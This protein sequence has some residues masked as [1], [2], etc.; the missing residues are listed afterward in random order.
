MTVRAFA[1]RFSIRHSAVI[2]WQKKRNN[3]TKMVW[4]TEKDIRLF[5]LDELENKSTALQDLYRSLK[6]VADET[7][8]PIVIDGKGLA[9]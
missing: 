7:T 4:S 2:K 6:E 3:H 8:S 9:A 5:V 1:D